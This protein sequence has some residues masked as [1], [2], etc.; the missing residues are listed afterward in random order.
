MEIKTITVC[1]ASQGNWLYKDEMVGSI[2]TRHFVSQVINADDSW[3]ECT[4]AERLAWEEAHKP[5]EIPDPAEAER[6]A[7]AAPTE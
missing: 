6:N 2:V 7:E 4:D 1:K 5:Q 3:Q